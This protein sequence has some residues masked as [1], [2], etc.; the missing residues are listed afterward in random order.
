[1]RRA[2]MAVG[3]F[4]VLT[5]PARAQTFGIPATLPITPLNPMALSGM[6]SFPCP[7]VLGGWSYCNSVQQWIA[8]YNKFQAEKNQLLEMQANIQRYATYPQ[9]LSSNVQGDL[10]RVSA[11]VNQNAGLSFTDQQIQST[12]ARLFPSY[13]PGA[14]YPAYTS[15]LSQATR[16]SVIN[17]L[18]VSGLE[19]S[20]S[21]RD[22]DLSTIVKTATANAT[23]P[24]QAVQALAQL[25]A[26]LIEQV[27]K[28]QRLSASS[29]QGAS[30]YYLA[31][32]ARKQTI[33]QA[34]QNALQQFQ[35]T[36][37]V[38]FPPLT[39]KQTASL[40]TAAGGTR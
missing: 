24:T 33:D 37:D 1:M 36:M 39:A 4:V 2:L 16:A 34:E 19:V 9:A 17:A 23:S 14:S 21:Q 22:A 32:T 35:A 29:I 26:V 6:A 40:A 15:Q 13:A 7:T 20:T 12:V 38:T 5:A 3:L 31:Q 30:A 11:L 8:M 27:Q 28:E 18:Q 25:L 10:R